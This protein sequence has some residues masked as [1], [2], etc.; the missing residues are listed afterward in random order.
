MS[1]RLFLIT[2]CPGAGKTTTCHALLQHFPLGVRIS[3]DDLRDQVV[4]GLQ[5]PRP[6][7]NDDIQLQFDLARESAAAIA[8]IYL[9]RGFTVA[10]DDLLPPEATDLMIER[11]GHPSPRK[12]ALV[13][14]V[15]VALHR[16][17]TRTNKNF[18][19]VELGSWI[20]GLHKDLGERYG[21]REDWEKIDSGQPLED[22][23]A[24]ILG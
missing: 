16:N 7:W 24:Q 9:S 18:D 23:V 11:I 20:P 6:D 12:V 8:K 3:V 4:S 15:D 2:G 14:V 10:I 21:A 17:M 22:V 5:P 13:P 1:P 19:P